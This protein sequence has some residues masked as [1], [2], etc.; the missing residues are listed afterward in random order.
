LTAFPGFQFPSAGT[1]PVL[2][3]I[4]SSMLHSG[5]GCHKQSLPLTHTF[6]ASPQAVTTSPLNL[7]STA[8]SVQAGVPRVSR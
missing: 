3:G 7:T 1:L 4:P 2:L 5:T 6:T 8:S